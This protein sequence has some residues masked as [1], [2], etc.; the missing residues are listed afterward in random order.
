MDASG[1]ALVNE[2]E[3]GQGSQLGACQEAQEPAPEGVM[4]VVMEELV[5][6]QALLW[7]QGLVLE[8]EQSQ[9]TLGDAVEQQTHHCH[10][11]P[12]P[13]GLW[14]PQGHWGARANQGAWWTSQ[15]S[16]SHQIL[17]SLR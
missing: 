6:S 4:E 14:T 8:L 12:V 9:G 15:G 10:L 5:P 17:L 2:Q 7:G 16:I 13:L 11:P 1:A 3:S